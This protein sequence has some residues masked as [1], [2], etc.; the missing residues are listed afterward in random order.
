MTISN[1]A[2]E[3][4]AKA[5]AVS[6]Y[7]RHMKRPVT[8]PDLLW[9]EDGTDAETMDD[10]RAAVR[11]ALEAAAPIIRAEAL[12]AAAVSIMA[13]RK[14]LHELDVQRGNGVFNIP[15]L[16]RILE[17]GVPREPERVVRRPVAQGTDLLGLDDIDGR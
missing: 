9:S 16:R 11:V 7:E 4:A 1:E 5:Q 10:Y 6:D 13:I 14:A 2:V 17:Q 12:E 8:D 3:A 15:A